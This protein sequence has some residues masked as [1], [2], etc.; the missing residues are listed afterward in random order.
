MSA[1]LLQHEKRVLEWL[2]NVRK[3][4]GQLVFVAAEKVA[5]QI[6]G[7]EIMKQTS[8]S[9]LMFFNCYQSACEKCTSKATP[10]MIRWKHWNFY[11]VIGVPATRLSRPNNP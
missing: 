1:G 6:F 4:Q 7:K 2:N 11:Q 9:A 10:I 8:A 5:L 3:G